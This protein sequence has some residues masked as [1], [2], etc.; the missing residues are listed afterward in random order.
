V[1]SSSRRGPILAG[2]VLRASRAESLPKSWHP[3]PVA[4]RSGEPYGG[5]RAQPDGARA[6]Q[7]RPGQRIRNWRKPRQLTRPAS[8]AAD[9]GGLSAARLA[10]R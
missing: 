2:W 9:R 1:P 6:L 3:S 8:C 7:E 4:I 10:A 5:D